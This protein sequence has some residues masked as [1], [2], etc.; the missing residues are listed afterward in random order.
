MK[1]R[2]EFKKLLN[3]VVLEIFEE[4]KVKDLLLMD[5]K[6]E[7]VRSGRIEELIKSYDKVLN[8]KS[9]WMFFFVSSGFIC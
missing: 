9:R 4:K 1:K 6:R 3:E 8:G 7:L 2:K 5:V